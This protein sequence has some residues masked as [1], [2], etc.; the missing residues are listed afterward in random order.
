MKNK[1]IL[2]SVIYLIPTV[3][4]FILPVITIPIFTRLISPE[5]YGALGLS[6][7]YA[8][9]MSGLANF[10]FTKAVERNYFK[11]QKSLDDLAKLLYS[12]LCF[13]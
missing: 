7:I 5:E 6:M 3:F 2:N 12:S 13:L 9:F 8:L 1:Q 4:G 10:G 11:Y